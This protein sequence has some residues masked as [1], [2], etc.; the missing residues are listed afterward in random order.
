M[1]FIFNAGCVG[2]VISFGEGKPL[3]Q[4][5][6]D[7]YLWSFPYYLVGAS[8][9]AAIAWFNRRFNWETSLLFVLSLI[10]I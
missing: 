5:L 1:Y 10:H 6:V 4:I 3:R 9:A 2:V 8:I 7:C